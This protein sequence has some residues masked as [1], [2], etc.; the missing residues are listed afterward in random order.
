VGKKRSREGK[1]ATKKLDQ[2]LGDGNCGPVSLSKAVKGWEREAQKGLNFKHQ[3][4]LREQVA[5]HAQNLTPSLRDRFFEGNYAEDAS[6]AEKEA[7]VK[8]W[9]RE[10]TQDGAHVDLLFCRLFADLVKANL[11]VYELRDGKLAVDSVFGR[12]L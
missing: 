10:A 7:F 1:K 11:T 12:G 9:A 4:F 2:T 5:K 3:A 6:F 8:Q